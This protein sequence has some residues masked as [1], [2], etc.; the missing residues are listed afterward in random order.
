MPKY[1]VACD[2]D[3]TLLTKDKKI[4]NKTLRFIKKFTDSGNYFVL[5]T[6]TQ[7]CLKIFI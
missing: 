6:G 2:L 5:C 4:T 7:V 3:D 1:L